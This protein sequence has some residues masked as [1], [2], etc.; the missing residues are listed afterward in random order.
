V[1]LRRAAFALARALPAIA[2]GL[3]AAIPVLVS[4]AHAVSDGWQPA[5]DDGIIVTRAWDVLTAH[6]PLVGQYSE[7]GT[8]TGQIVHSPGPLLYWLL[9]LPAHFGSTASL[10]VTMG[11]MNT[12]AIIGCVVLA[13]RRGGLVLMF[14]AAVGIALMCQSLAAESFH[15]VWNPAAALFPFLLLIFL[16]WSLACGEHRLLPLTMLVASFVTQTHLTYVAPTAGL[17]V[18]G[19]CGLVMHRLAH[20]RAAPVADAAEGGEGAEGA[21]GAEAAEGAEGAEG[22]PAHAVRPR[23]FWRWVAAAVVVVAVCWAAPLLDEIEHSPG[24]L[25]LIV[26][27]TSDRGTTLGATIGWNAVVDAVGWKPWWLYIPKSEWDRKHDVRATPSSSANDSTLAILAALGLVLLVGLWRRRGDLAAAAAIGLVL[28]AALAANVSQTPVAPLLA[29]T[30][31]YTAWWGSMLGL[32]VWLVLAWSLWCALRR[33]ACANSPARRRLA[34]WVKRLPEWTLPAACVVAS[35]G[36]LGATVA[37]AATVAAKQ[38]PDSHVNQYHPIAAIVARLDQIVPAGQNVRVE[39]GA[40][41]VSTLPIEPAV[42]FGLVRH[43]DLVLSRGAHQRL[44]YYYELENKPYRWFVF[45][46]DGMRSRN[47]MLRAITVHFHD[48]W[49]QHTFSAWVARV[50][51]GRSLQLPS[52][53]RTDAARA[54]VG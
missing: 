38:E 10:A 46:A 34:E 39:L 3:A 35:M 5:A 16:S 52:A 28:C 2:A 17:L 42:R 40:T 13:R 54:G 32:W 18:V 45:I 4:T 14:A 31:G 26:Q 49:G 22:A 15:D 1:W 53:I 8:V 43:G 20:R 11:A 24:N 19:V 12:L 41:N 47:H 44:G 7:A 30:I 50:G 9:A 21:E 33:L 36:A 27:T 29:A 23:P 51:P 6:S 48:F 37:T 25:T